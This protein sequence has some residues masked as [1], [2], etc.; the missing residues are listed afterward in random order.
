MEIIDERRSKSFIS[1]P[2]LENTL[3]P[4]EKYDFYDE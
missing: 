2:E 4:E 1:N 3:S